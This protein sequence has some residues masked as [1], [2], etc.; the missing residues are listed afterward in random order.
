MSGESK[1]QAKEEEKKKGEMKFSKPTFGNKSNK[2]EF[3]SLDAN[4]SKSM[5]EPL[6]KA[7]IGG[8]IG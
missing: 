2:K 7:A 6:S 3:P 8:P 4:S 5:P 1:S